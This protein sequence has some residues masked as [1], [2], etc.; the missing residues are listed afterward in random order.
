MV[1]GLVSIITPCYNGE[2][3]LAETIES[4]LSQTYPDWE[5]LIVDDGS[6]DRSAEIAQ[7]YADADPRVIV[8]R[9]RNKGSA[10]ARNKGIRYARGQYIALLDADD[11]WDARFLEKQIAFLREK[12]AVC[13]YCSY[14]RIDGASKEIMHPTIAQ[15]VVTTRD[16]RVMNHIGCL[17][18]LYDSSKYGKVLLREELKSIR[19][20][21]AYWYDIVALENRAYGNPEVLAKYRVLSD[22]VTGNKLS[23]VSK[24]FAFYRRYLKENLLLASIN[25]LRWGIAGIRKFS[26]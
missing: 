7:R 17:S 18:G 13:V 22:S 19:D 4:V 23:L 2:K 6:S 1:E 3:Y 16:M 25:T 9:Q 8:M 5:M 14:S 26:V 20:D 12:Q 11:L 10:A 21:Y 15:Q 24:Q